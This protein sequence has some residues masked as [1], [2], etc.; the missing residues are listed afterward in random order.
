MN[1]VTDAPAAE[2]ATGQFNFSGVFAAV[3]TPVGADLVPDVARHAD[4]C[5]WLLKSGCDGLGILGTTGEANS[6]SVDERITVMEGLVKAGIPAEKLM[7]GTGCC[8]IVDS[9]VLTKKAL[10]LGC[11]GV[12]ALPPYYYKGVSDDGLFTA[13]SEVIDRVND[14]RLRLYFYHF[15]AMSATPISHD[16]IGRLRGRYGDMVSGMKDS[17]GVV[18]NMTGA[19][20]KNPGFEVFAG[21][22]PA[23]LPL[24]RDGGAGCITA[25]CNVMP[26]V[27]ADIY[28]NSATDAA[29]KPH[30]LACAIRDI[31][32]SVPVV[33]ALRALVARNRGDEVW[34]RPLP[35]LMA[36]NDQ[37]RGELFEKFDATGYKMPPL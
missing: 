31:V 8:S 36:L 30:Q 27:L 24:M 34:A 13:Y 26:D 9:V 37:Q 10:E 12:L 33:G 17:S 23:L 4:H 32:T 22:D 20:H 15:P 3:L 11:K 7:P 21:A 6:L 1:D 25:A 14:P 2:S 5:R 28:A 35:P 29:E 19:L 18:E 16:L